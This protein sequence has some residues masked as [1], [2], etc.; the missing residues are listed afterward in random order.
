MGLYARYLLPRLT[1]LA[2]SHEQLR[3]YRERVIELRL[4][5]PLATVV[6]ITPPISQKIDPITT[7]PIPQFRMSLSPGRLL[8]SMET[9][10]MTHR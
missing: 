10:S 5:P 2:M 6:S 3:P 1:H 8:R 9:T 4:E 7:S